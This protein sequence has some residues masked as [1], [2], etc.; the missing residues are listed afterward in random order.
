MQRA[1]S[2]ALRG[3]G[4]VHP[5]PLVGCVLVKNGKV[6]GEGY[7][8]RFGDRHAEQMA[9]AQAGSRAKGA[10]AYV[11]LEPCAHWGKTPPCA[12]ALVSAGIREVYIADIDPNPKVKGRGVRLLKKAG[13][14]VHVGLERAAARHINRAF[15]TWMTKNRPYVVL[16]MAATLDGKIATR[17]GES[18]WI[19]GVES[20]QLVH[21]L[22]AESDAVLVG[23]TTAVKDNPALSSHGVG[24]DPL[25]IV[26]D[27]RL[28]TSP[29]LNIYRK[30]PQPTWIITG[31]KVPGARQKR[32][33]K[34]GHKILR[35]SL[36]NRKSKVNKLLSLLAKN[37][38]SQLLIEGGGETSWPFLSSKLVDELYLFL[39]PKILGGRLAPTWVGGEGFA[40]MGQAL[41]LKS[42][43]VAR[44]GSDLLIRGF[45]N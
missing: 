8:A 40:R 15:I 24:R 17:T 6:V 1:F 22:R 11:N 33:E 5:N 37:N 36:K 19:S 16:K 12:P 20:R 39:A 3:K 10:T 26:L 30:S 41:E 32:M 44:L 29:A 42:M 13:L 7:H 27:P 45:L 28:R 2:L 31:A 4:W 14:K 23:A 34:A 38:I 18:R 9:L 43:S 25:R 21:Q 35:E